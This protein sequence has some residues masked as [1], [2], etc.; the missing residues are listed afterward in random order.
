MGKHKLSTDSFLVLPTAV[1]HEQLVCLA[2]YGAI[3]FWLHTLAALFLGILIWVHSS[4]NTLVLLVWLV[5]I[6][7]L[8]ASCWWSS[9]HFQMDKV[10]EEVLYARVQRYVLLSTLLHALWGASGIL[11][12]V[13]QLEVVAVHTAVLL[14]ISLAALPTLL[15]SWPIASVQMIAVILPMAVML[16]WLDDP[17]FRLL[18]LVLLT[19]AI[20]VVLASRPLA[21]LMDSFQLAQRKLLEQMNTD[22][23]TQLANRRQFEQHFKLEWRRSARTREP[24]ALLVLGID[25]LTDLDLSEQCLIALARYLKAVVHRAGDLVARY[26]DRRFIVLSPTT[27]TDEVAR[28]AE[29]FRH[30]IE[31]KQLTC[32]SLAGLTVSIGAASCQPQSSHHQAMAEDDVHDVA[33]PALLLKAAEQALQTAQE[34]GGN[35]IVIGAVSI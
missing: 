27:S 32:A 4:T 34:Q 18:G 13:H 5:G 33:Y 7:L 19:A 2:S 23:V 24:L 10:A 6:A 8:A 9:S 31:R 15:L 11:L 21:Q 26:D 3:L 30:E 12:F 1:M 20:M 29:K 35:C 14:L 25:Q 22:P 17:I 28:L 16:L